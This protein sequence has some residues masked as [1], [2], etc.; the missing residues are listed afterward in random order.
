MVTFVLRSVSATTLMKLSMTELMP[1]ADCAGG[2]A[3]NQTI[4]S[5]HILKT[6]GGS[7]LLQVSAAGK[8]ACDRLAE[9]MGIPQ[10]GLLM[11]V[12]PATTRW[13]AI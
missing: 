3:G 11:G 2:N 10:Y 8:T 12:E 13:S 1:P 6:R 4:I 5:I 9:P 7:T